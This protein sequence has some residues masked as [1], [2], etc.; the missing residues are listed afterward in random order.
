MIDGTP[1]LLAGFIPPMIAAIVTGIGGALGIGGGTGAAAAAGAA[2]LWGAGAGA[3]AGAAGAIAPAAGAAAAGAGAGALGG[4][5]G[6]AAGTL[7]GTAGGA[8]G[9]TTGGTLVGGG[10]GG[11]AGGIFGSGIGA[12]LAPATIASVET[13]LTG[14]AISGATTGIQAAIGSPNMPDEFA[15]ELP[16][17]RAARATRLNRIKQR[18]GY[19]ASILS[20]LGGMSRARLGIPTVLGPGS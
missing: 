5:T 7:G 3:G 4:A 2:S 15:S 9:G 6:A 17:G 13:G 19:G 18:R 14:L 12:S 11:G 8:L 16:E 10:V 1:V 20:P